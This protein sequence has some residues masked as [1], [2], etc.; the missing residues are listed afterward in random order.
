M[1]GGW[2]LGSRY[3][4]FQGS[5]ETQFTEAFLAQDKLLS[6]LRK[7]ASETG[8]AVAGATSDVCRLSSQPAAVHPVEGDEGMASH[9][10][11]I[12]DFVRR[13]RTR[14]RFGSLSRAPLRLLR[15]ELRGAVAECD[16]IARPPDEWDASLPRAVGERHATLQALEDAIAVRG[17]LFRVLPGLEGAV[18]Q[19]FHQLPGEFPELV[20]KGHVHRAERAPAGIRSVAMRARLYGFQFWLGDGALEPLETEELAVNG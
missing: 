13:M 12:G 7:L 19:V 4:S 18:L 2:R 8:F 16:W 6:M 11:N 17:L 3:L 15:F 14:A 20:I 1:C 5:A 10:W 9:L